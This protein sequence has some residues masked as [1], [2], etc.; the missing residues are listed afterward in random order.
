MYFLTFFLFCYLFR[1]EIFWTHGELLVVAIDI[2]KVCDKVWPQ[3]SWRNFHLRD[4]KPNLH[5]PYLFMTTI[6]ASIRSSPVFLKAQLFSHI[7]PSSHRWLIVD[8]YPIHYLRTYK[9]FWIGTTQILC[10]SMTQRFRRVTFLW[11]LLKP[12]LFGCPLLGI[13][14]IF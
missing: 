9:S 8:L 13:Y 14:H 5:F 6:P 11:N 1:V 12:S 10:H 2:S 3:S 7:I 4:S